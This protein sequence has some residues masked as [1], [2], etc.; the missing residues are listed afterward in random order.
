MTKIIFDHLPPGVVF[1]AEIIEQFGRQSPAINTELRGLRCS[2][3]KNRAYIE[4]L[5]M[6][7][8]ELADMCLELAQQLEQITAGYETMLKG[9]SK[10]LAR[11]VLK[12]RGIK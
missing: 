2:K 8:K 9:E 6:E 12:E 11:I 1:S 3:T 4:Q 10:Q 5:Q 7:N